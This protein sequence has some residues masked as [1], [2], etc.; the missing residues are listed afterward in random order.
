MCIDPGFLLDKAGRSFYW[1]LHANTP[2]ADRKHLL[3]YWAAVVE[4]YAQWVVGQTYQGRGALTN[5]PRFPNNDEACDLMIKEGS[6]L[7]LI[8]IKASILTAKAKYSFDA[9]LLKD[10]LLR[11]AIR[12]DEEERKGIA[13]LHRA[14]QR[15][16]DGEA[17]GGLIPAQIRTIY[18]ILVFL[19]KS[20]TSPYLG[21]LYREHFDRTTL[22]RR[23]TTTPPYAITISDLESILPYTHLHDLTDIIDEYYRCNR[24]AD[25]AVAFGR[26]AHAN[27]PLLRDTPRGKDV[28][29]ERFG[30]FC[31]DLINNTFPPNITEK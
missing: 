12:G 29:R 3:G 2:K 24:T 10:E 8:E 4:R 19:D 16:H 14:I 27:I 31:D 30:Q 13:Q 21:T 20:F 1:T 23:P 9:E 25:G 11:K 17:I 18:P 26:F 6:R 5:S 22:K 7:V 15:F 28:V